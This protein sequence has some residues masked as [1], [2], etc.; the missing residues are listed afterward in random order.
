MFLDVDSSEG[1][2]H[3]ALSIACHFVGFH[4][5]LIIL[6]VAYIGNQYLEV[7]DSVETII[8]LM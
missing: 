7:Y 5:F 1:K 6:E 4:E 3:L 8:I 2:N